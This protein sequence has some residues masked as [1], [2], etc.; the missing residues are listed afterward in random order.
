M[1]RSS[2]PREITVEEHPTE[3][4]SQGLGREETRGR[5]MARGPS[6]AFCADSR[7]Q[8]LDGVAAQILGNDELRHGAARNAALRAWASTRPAA[9]AMAKAASDEFL[10]MFARVLH[11]SPAPSVPRPP[12]FDLVSEP[13]IACETLQG[14]PLLLGLQETLL[15]AHELGAVHD[16]SPLVTAVLH[17]LLLA[18]LHRI[19]G[20]RSLEDWTK[21]WK[22]PR[23]RGPA[24]REYFEIWG[25]RFDLFDPERPFLQVAGL[26][27]ILLRERGGKAMDAAALAV[28][29]AQLAVDAAAAAPDDPALQGAALVAQKAA[30]KAQKAA[31]KAQALSP[32]EA[33]LA[34]PAARLAPERSTHC[35][36]AYFFAPLPEGFSISPAEAARAMLAFL[37]Y[38]SGGRVQND[39][40]SRK[41]GNLRSG[42]IMLLT[43]ATLRE[44]LLLNL[45]ALAEHAQGDGPPWER[46]P[47]ARTERSPRGPIDALVWPSRRVMLV[48][49]RLPDGSLIVRDVVTAAGE[50]MDGLYADR[51]FAYVKRE[52]PAPVAV[53]IDPVR[54][55]WR[56]FVAL[57]DPATGVGAFRWPAACAQ[58]AK[59]VEASVLPASTAVQVELLGLAGGGAGRAAAIKDWRV[60][61]YPLPLSLFVSTARVEVLRRALS[62]AEDMADAIRSR[63]LRVLSDV[64]IVNPHKERVA[65]HREHLATLPAYWKALGS[66]FLAWLDELGAIVADDL[67]AQG[68]RWQ[69]IVREVAREVVLQAITDIGLKGRAIRA[70]AAGD[71]VFAK[72]LEELVPLPEGVSEDPLKLP[73]HEAP[74]WS[75]VKG[76]LPHL[77]GLVKGKNL[78]VLAALRRSLQDPRG[79]APEAA[80]HVRPFL[81][82]KATQRQAK[83][84][85]LIAAWRAQHRDEAKGVSLGHAFRKVHDARGGDIHDGSSTTAR[86]EALLAAHPDDIGDL[87]TLS[88]PLIYEHGA[89]DW[90]DLLYALLF[91]GRRDRLVQRKLAL[92][93]FEGASSSRGSDRQAQARAP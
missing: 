60:D 5:F 71:G 58:L 8:A 85:Y 55:T 27:A 21:L 35:A 82:E 74:K 64:L 48:P 26:D 50:D 57:V 88:L 42:A 93:Y 40:A 29:K 3:Q 17:R 49:L 65:E 19:F 36:A 75:D 18:I 56:D 14:E 2:L 77:E 92:D 83:L 20:P 4:R 32:D 51:M 43:G 76:F 10:G 11:G 80:A 59:L 69:A 25:G 78:G 53:R 47:T 44:T 91:W 37:A 72:V 15:R 63:V 24:L 33:P 70:G 6:C 41:A 30:E 87:L 16:E 54:A 61:R 67:D 90:G 73:A 86:F 45:V 23:F 46:D 28:A 39:A 34:T 12:S 9:V 52:E 84:Y 1:T 62:L 66:R 81:P 22:V 68:L 89:L 38:T 13:W 79:M 31:S 7:E